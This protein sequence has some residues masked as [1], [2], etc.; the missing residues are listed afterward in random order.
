VGEGAYHAIY[1]SA[2]EKSIFK[3]TFLVEP[4]FA[5]A[6]PNA[7]S[8]NVKQLA[9]ASGSSVVMIDNLSFPSNVKFEILEAKTNTESKMLFE[10]FA[11]KQIKV[12]INSAESNDGGPASPLFAKVT[13]SVTEEAK[14][15]TKLLP[16]K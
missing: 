4:K 13:R 15:R 2:G 3:K 9:S 5:N 8:N 14:I 16:T 12:E 7:N 10:Q 11:A 6:M 1:A